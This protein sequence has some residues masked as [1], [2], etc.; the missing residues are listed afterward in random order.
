MYLNSCN[1]AARAKSK[2]AQDWFNSGSW[3]NGL[4]L[5]PHESI[6]V[7]EFAKQYHKNPIWWDE[8][9]KFLKT[10]ELDRLAPGNYV[11]DSNNVIAMVSKVSPKDKDST[12]WEAHRNFNDLQYIIR[13]KAKMGVTSISEPGA[14]VTVPY[15]SADNENFTVNGG[16]YY[17]AEP[18]TFFIFSPKE[19]HRPAFKVDGYDSIKKI[20]IKVRVP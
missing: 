12:K 7:S 15:S 8:A 19:I 18:G 9:F 10:Q 17:D 11:I 6:N 1:D 20:V 14:K 4:Q 16:R 2:K 13:G 5:K 3:L